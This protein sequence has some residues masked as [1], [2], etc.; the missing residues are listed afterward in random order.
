MLALA[1]FAAPLAIWLSF[2]QRIVSAGGLTAFVAAAAGRRVA[3]AHGWIWAFAYFLYLP[4]TI[5]FVVYDL[6]PPV[7]PGVLAYRSALELALPVAIVLLVLAPLRV[8]LGA[9]GVLAVAQLATMLVLAGFELAHTSPSFASSPTLDDTGRATGGTALLFVCASLPLY[10]GAEVRGGSVV[11][12][13]GLAAAVA[14]VGGA[15]L[16]AAIP[17]ADVPDRLRDA[18]VPGAAIAQAYSGRSL[19]VVVGLLTAASVLALVVAEYLALARLLHWL[20]GPPIR[21]LVAWTAVPFIALDAISLAGPDRF[22]DDLLKPSLGALFVS[23]L[24]VFA[25][26][27]RFRRSPLAVG[28]ALV[29][30]G[31]AVWG[32]YTLVAG[33]AST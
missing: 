4:Y 24:V 8:V 6:L 23:L 18:A 10:L 32:L 21:T 26:Y 3:L 33:G 5:T 2:S 28:T 13:R 14:I 20:H 12:R 15:L 27:P 19:A 16:V 29:A 30:S 9:L 11:V 7:F 22:Y 17:L 1:V 25:L 31:L